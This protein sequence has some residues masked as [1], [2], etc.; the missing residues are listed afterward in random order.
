MHPEAPEASAKPSSK[1][2]NVDKTDK[3]DNTYISFFVY[4]T[5]Y[6]GSFHAKFVA[7]DKLR[8]LIFTSEQKKYCTTDPYVFKMILEDFEHLPAPLFA[9][10][11]W[12]NEAVSSLPHNLLHPALATKY[13]PSC[14]SC[15]DHMKQQEEDD[16]DHDALW[17]EWLHAAKRIR[18]ANFTDGCHGAH[19]LAFVLLLD[20]S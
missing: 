20:L 14:S 19:P 3:T 10:F 17:T 9:L 5:S 2:P 18:V 4:I 15:Y 6:E 7:P 11:D 12:I 16:D 1:K 13:P 8:N